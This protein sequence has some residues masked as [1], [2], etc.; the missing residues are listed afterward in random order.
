MQPF[1][2]RSDISDFA[3][4]LRD[5]I[6]VDVV[7]NRDGSFDATA[8][9]IPNLLRIQVDDYRPADNEEWDVDKWEARQGTI[10]AP[11]THAF[12]RVCWSVARILAAGKNA[13]VDAANGKGMCIRLPETVVMS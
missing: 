1:F 13:Y 12:W 6:F 3:P 2:T 4:M 10:F 7:D 11:A 9:A 5:H 8:P